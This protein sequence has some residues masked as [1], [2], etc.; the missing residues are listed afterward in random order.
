MLLISLVACVVFWRKILS[1]SAL[2]CPVLRSKLLPGHHV[3]RN[4]GA[5][6]YYKYF[7][8]VW[9]KSGPLK[10]FAVFSATV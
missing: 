4:H 5:I 1:I 10:F 2:S 7:Y 3:D 6:N 9:Q 8:R